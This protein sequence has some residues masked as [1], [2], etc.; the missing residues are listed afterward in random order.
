MIKAKI[1]LLV[2]CMSLLSLSNNIVL[3]DD[4]DIEIHIIGY[5]IDKGSYEEGYL[6]TVATV[7]G[8]TYHSAENPESVKE[9]VGIIDYIIGD[10]KLTGEIK[11]KDNSGHNLSN[12]PVLVWLKASDFPTDI[13]EN[14]SNIRFTDSDG[15]NK[16]LNY[17]IESWDN[18]SKTGA[19]WVKVPN[20]PA[21]GE[22]KIR[23]GYVDAKAPPKS[24]GDA[25]FDFFDDFEDGSVD[26]NK[27]VI[28]SDNGSINEVDGELQIRSNSMADS[29]VDLISK[30]KYG[31][32]VAMKFRAGVSEGHRLDHKG[33]GF[34]SDNAGVNFNQLENYIYW[35]GQK[36]KLYVSNKYP[37]TS[38]DEVCCGCTLI[39]Q[40]YA[41]GYRTWEIRWLDSEIRYY[42]NGDLEATHTTESTKTKITPRFS[43]NTYTTAPADPADISVD[44]VFVRNCTYSEP[45]VEI[46][47]ISEEEILGSGD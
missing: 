42:I 38:A 36:D 3:A 29:I 16:E 39:E 25:T 37:S 31:P 22:T 43:L 14:G 2:M 24:D 33:L 13:T 27:W 32:G 30:E 1:S 45:T 8:G 4:S 46:V 28:Y 7:T 18:N 47:E 19:V 15:K 23:M 9:L 21:N 41:P 10:I 6:Q 5:D 17:W 26:S 40:N 11:I 34:M 12:Y 20:I 35:R 44:W